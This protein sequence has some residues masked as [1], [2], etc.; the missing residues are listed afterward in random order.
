M[1]SN[2]AALDRQLWQ[3]IRGRLAIRR[4]RAPLLAD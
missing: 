1:E 2:G 4:R 3:P